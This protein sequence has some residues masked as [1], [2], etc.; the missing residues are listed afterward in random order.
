MSQ[1]KAYTNPQCFHTTQ[2]DLKFDSETSDKNYLL[3]PMRLVEG[4]QYQIDAQCVH[5]LLS[6]HSNPAADDDHSLY[7]SKLDVRRL[8]EVEATFSEAQALAK[9]ASKDESVLKQALSSLTGKKNNIDESASLLD[10][11]YFHPNRQN[12]VKQ[13]R[14]ETFGYMARHK[15][16]TSV[17]RAPVHIVQEVRAASDS[18][19]L[20]YGY[21][22]TGLGP[23]PNCLQPKKSTGAKQNLR[24]L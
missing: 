19:K 1:V 23:N 22:L 12:S 13:L 8:Y 14:Q 5:D 21:R 3:V 4:G 2:T 17:L 11:L 20:I 24:T 10:Y 7:M 16:K 15:V 6:N 9:P 18:S